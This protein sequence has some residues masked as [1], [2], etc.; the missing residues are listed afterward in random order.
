MCVYI[1]IYTSIYI[2]IYIYTSIYMQICQR[3]TCIEKLTEGRGKDT[4]ET[5]LYCFHNN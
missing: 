3:R 2:Y 5:S 1:Y 4:L